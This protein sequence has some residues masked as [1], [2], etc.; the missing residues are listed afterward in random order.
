MERQQSGVLSA[1]LQRSD[2]ALGE[3]A[4]VKEAMWNKAEENA[5]ALREAFEAAT[6]RAAEEAERRMKEALARAERVYQGKLALALVARDAAAA[7]RARC[8]K[9]SRE[10]S[11]DRSRGRS[12]DERRGWDEAASPAQQRSDGARISPAEHEEAL[13]AALD[14]QRAEHERQLEAELAARDAEALEALRLLD[15]Q[16]RRGDFGRHTVVDAVNGGG[17]GG[18]GHG[19]SGSTPPPSIAASASVP[20]RSRQREAS[21][22]PAAGAAGAVVAAIR[23]AA[24]ARTEALR[25]ATKESHRLE[26]AMSPS[27]SPVR[28]DPGRWYVAPL[29]RPVPKKTGKL[30]TGDDNGV[31]SNSSGL[32]HDDGGGGG[33]RY[34]H[35]QHGGEVAGA[36]GGSGTP[37]SGGH[38]RR[39]RREASAGGGGG[40]D[41]LAA[42]LRVSADAGGG[43]GGGGSG[44]EIGHREPEPGGAD[45]AD[46]GLTDTE[47]RYKRELEALRGRVWELEGMVGGRLEERERAYRRKLRA[48]VAECRSSRVRK[49]EAP[50]NNGAPFKS[51]APFKHPAPVSETASDVGARRGGDTG[52]LGPQGGGR[53]DGPHG[54][55]GSSSHHGSPPREGQRTLSVTIRSR[56]GARGD[57]GRVRS[58]SHA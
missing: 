6:E 48:A 16:H 26:E 17:G 28:G 38:R 11:R 18:G 1:A 2:A 14:A 31:G 23:S 56:Q 57:G 3:V 54:A 7:G 4:R 34:H 24:A 19:D 36:P 25:G 35:Q 51:G 52:A 29:P 13:R 58:N 39:R 20:A 53:R 15:S 41:D 44:G 55:G 42:V 21:T 40:G 12:P 22:K 49:H 47:K 9:R 37:R 5:D 32:S 50:S 46:P 43:G 33:G 30:V 10:R 8:E 45:D 27:P